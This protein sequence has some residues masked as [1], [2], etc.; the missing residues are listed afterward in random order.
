[1]FIFNGISSKDMGVVL[2]DDTPLLATP[3]INYEQTDIE[4]RDGAVYTA[5]NFQDMS[6]TLSVTL[7]DLH[8]QD[9]V[10]NW[11]RGTGVFEYNGRCKE[12]RIFDGIT[13]SKHGPFKYKFTVKLIASPYWY[14]DDG[15]MRVTDF[16]TNEGN[17]TAKPVIRIVG[18]EDID[19]TIND[20]R[21]GIALSEEHPEI[22]I[23][24]DTQSE[25]E[26]KLISIGY[27]YPTLKPGY[28]KVIVNAGTP[29]IYIKRKDLWI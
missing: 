13:Y 29:E 7:L 14:I 22:I 11:L 20:V 25:T 21:F 19:V 8:K 2:E 24:S 9:A 15:Y 6:I 16:V 18:T 3:N 27:R 1:M 26:P 17:V 28:N 5:L 12:I 4:G 10:K 23:H